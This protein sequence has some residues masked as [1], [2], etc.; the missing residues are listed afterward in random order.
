MGAGNSS[1]VDA[2]SA[3]ATATEHPA[4]GLRV[5]VQATPVDRSRVLPQFLI[6]Y[7]PFRAA[8]V[9]APL[10][11]AHAGFTA[12]LGGRWGICRILSPHAIARCLLDA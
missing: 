3:A 1:R 12:E 11:D 10:P 6:D 2:A 5:P 4:L 7:G 9:A 8:P